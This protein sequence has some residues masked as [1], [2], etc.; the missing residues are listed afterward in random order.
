MKKSLLLA[1]A[2]ATFGVAQA[3]EPYKAVTPEMV[4][5]LQSAGVEMV[6]L[7]ATQMNHVSEGVNILST[8]SVS[9]KDVVARKDM[10][11]QAFAG[12]PTSKTA[13][14][15]R[16]S[17]I[18]YLG[19]NARIEAY[20]AP[21]MV[22]AP[23][24]EQT[25]RNISKQATQEWSYGIGDAATGGGTTFV[26][27]D[28]DLTFAYDDFTFSMTPSL[29]TNDGLTWTTHFVNKEMK[30][31]PGAVTSFGLPNFD[32]SENYQAVSCVPYHGF[33]ALYGGTQEKKEFLLG[34]NETVFDI[35]AFGVLMTKPAV[36]Y[37]LESVLGLALNLQIKGA[38]EL[39]MNVYEVAEDGA[40]SEQPLMVGIATAKDVVVAGQDSE[41]GDNL[42]TV[43]FKFY[44]EDDLGGLEQ[45]IYHA[46]TALYFEVT[47]YKTNKDVTFD[48]FLANWPFGDEQM[49][50]SPVAAEPLGY[51]EGVVDG[52]RGL[53]PMNNLFDK[54]PY[55]TPSLYV[56][57][58]FTN[59]DFDKN[60]L[61]LPAAGGQANLTATGLY[62]LTQQ[63]FFSVTNEIPEWLTIMF[64]ASNPQAGTF[65]LVF[66]AQPLP[67]G[68]K[69]R[70]A[71]LSFTTYF[72]GLQTVVVTQGE[73]SVDGVTVSG[74]KVTVEGGNFVVSSVDAN[75]VEVFNLSGQKV[76]EAAFD[77]EAVVS[78]AGL[79]SGV[80]IVKFNDNT[81][82]KVVK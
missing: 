1:M 60:Q 52:K 16:P 5:G 23:F 46:S 51:V 62:D 13:T 67:A 58:L 38:G 27:K 50:M 40:L 55:A 31:V 20:P 30:V 59:I 9:S 42:C 37:Y 10:K 80:Y 34:Q 74:S 26:S 82:V 36:P 77:G 33:T 35:S 12:E 56:N 21:Y 65:E 2:V 47:D 14:Y 72:G 53:I 71:E 63:G 22:T 24:V 6:K 17:G 69:G 61:Q 79:A 70:T 3:A 78:G 73:S 45:I 75:A 41:T 43:E 19:P 28:Q 7:Q 8:T 18:Y 39:R 64:G 15:L 76:A 25:W 4:E 81:V 49:S 32:L 44:R 54:L 68:E 48:C 57:G 66:E 29:T 11:F